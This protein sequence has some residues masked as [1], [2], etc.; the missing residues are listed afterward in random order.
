MTI[1]F[2]F[3]STL[4]SKESLDEVLALALQDTV[5]A[6]AALEA[7]A[8]ITNA[9]MEGSLAFTESVKKRLAVAT[10]QRHHF[11]NVGTQLTNHLTPGI[12][13]LIRTLQDRLHTV[14]IISGGFRE[15]ILPTAASLHIA[16]T[17][18]FCNQCIFDD[19]D[20]VCG[21]DESLP[22]F[23]DDGKT[24]VIEHIAATQAP[25]RPYV[26]IG[27]G[28]NDLAAHHNGSVEYFCGFTQ[29]V[30]RSV[31]LDQAPVHVPNVAALSDFLFS[32]EAV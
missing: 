9:G 20:T 2:D 6:H 10:V 14:Y 26:L 19:T 27:D 22:T 32:I 16:P 25:R 8:A 31:I 24:P 1:F 4:V 18:I 30:T 17:Q 23:T 28:A 15:T 29:H 13:P 21:I 7:I 5:D 3:D 11:Q 12:R